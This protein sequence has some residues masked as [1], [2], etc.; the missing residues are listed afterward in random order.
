MEGD[1]F[2][3]SVPVGVL[4][5]KLGDKAVHL[6]IDHHAIEGQENQLYSDHVV[7]LDLNLNVYAADGPDLG[8]AF[9][10]DFGSTPMLYQPPGCPPQLAV[11]NKNGALYIYNRNAIGS[12]AMQVLQISVFKSSGVEG[13]FVGDPV[14]YPV[15][16]LIYTGNSQDNDAGTFLHGLIAL[17]PQ[18]DCTLALAWQKQVGINGGVGLY[19]NPVTP[20]IAANG[21]VYYATSIHG[22]VY[23]FDG[24]T[25]QQ[26]WDSG[27]LTEA[28]IYAAPTVV[29]G[30]L[31]VATFDNKIY[32][33]GLP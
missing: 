15:F 4:D 12:G 14:Y 22:H 16:N 8:G 25:G 6:G 28:G 13:L 26:L 29:N 10:F 32:A 24:S 7:R 9:D 17:V 2:E 27:L 30:Q 20:P 5:D 31:F 1:G 3:P 19:L 11:M 33:F 23:A 21:V 18:A